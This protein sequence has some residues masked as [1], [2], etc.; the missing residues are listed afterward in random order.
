MG[1]VYLGFAEGERPVA[2]KTL[3]ADAVDSARARMRREATLLAAVVSP[4]LAR[5]VDSDL[6]SATP[7]LAMQYVQ[8]PTLLEIDLPLSDLQLY[9]LATGLAEALAMLHSAGIVHRDVKPGNV[10]LTH[11][12]PVLVDLG[13]AH[14]PKETAVTRTGSLLGSPGWMAPE[15]LSGDEVG[16]AADVWA[17][18]ALLAYAATG[19]APFGAGTFEVM[20]VRVLNEQYDL[21]GVPAWLSPAVR[22]VL[23][24]DPAR[25]P[26][27]PRLIEAMGPQ[28]PES[29]PVFPT[30]QSTRTSGW[31]GYV[32]V[33]QPQVMSARSQSGWRAVGA[34]AAVIV[35]ALV[36]A[37]VVITSRSGSNAAEV[38]DPTARDSVAA[39]QTTSSAAATRTAAVN[40]TSTSEQST[41]TADGDMIQ[42]PEGKEVLAALPGGGTP[43]VFP[44]AITGYSLAQEWRDTLRTFEGDTEWSILYEFPASMNGC[45]HRRI[46]IRWRAAYSGATI[47][48]ALLSYDASVVFEGPESGVSGWMASYGC[49]QPG[50][51]LESL[52]G[53]GNLVDVVVEVQVWEISV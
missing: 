9:Q 7:W 22:S 26:S 25:R 40:T 15:R 47:K 11:S 12:G 5:L 30:L 2:V 1:V 45:A 4:R 41:P 36:L 39:S 28:L 19:A 32:G 51:Q 17:W 29:S 49:A 14:S 21:A 20:S 38:P 31:G 8:G 27:A 42:V 37:V 50:F 24:R 46:V 10:I 3:A 52:P 13:I 6:D 18:G 33:P 34:L 23:I 43:P 53:E 35:V 48:S 16:T 44:L